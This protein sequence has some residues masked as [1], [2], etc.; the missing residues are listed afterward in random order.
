M[1]FERVCLEFSKVWIESRTVTKGFGRILN[2]FMWECKPGLHSIS[3]TIEKKTYGNPMKTH[4]NP[5]K[6]HGN[7]IKTH[8]N[9][10]KTFGN[11]MKTYGKPME[12]YGKPIEIR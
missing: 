4:E 9:P 1:G 7:L 3:P 5:V 12:T 8:G 6:T 2:G 11:P 10:M